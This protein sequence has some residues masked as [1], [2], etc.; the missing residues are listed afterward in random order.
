MKQLFTILMLTIS[1]VTFSQTLRTFNGAFSDSRVPNGTATY[2]FYEDPETREYVKHGSF[3]YSFKGGN[4]P[5]EGLNQTITGGFIKGL[6]NGIWTYTVSLIDYGTNLGT[7]NEY[8]TGTIS[9]VANYNNG[10]ADGNWKSV[11]SYKIRKKVYSYGTLVWD[12]FGPLKTMSINM[13]FKEGKLVGA[14]NINDGFNNFKAN[15]SYDN[16]SLCTGT[17]ILEESNSDQEFIYKDNFLYDYVAREKSGAVRET[18]KF[19]VEYDNLIEAREMNTKEREDSG[20]S[21]DTIECGNFDLVCAPTRYINEYFGKLL[22]RFYFL[23]ESIGGD[24]SFKEGFSGGNHLTVSK[25]NYTALSEIQ[26]FKTAEEKYNK[27]DFV[28]A[29]R[30]YET[31]DL[32]IL[33]PD[34]KLILSDKIAKAEQNVVQLIKLSSGRMDFYQKYFQD[35]FINLENDLNYFSQNIGFDT[36]SD[37]K[38]FRKD[39]GTIDGRYIIQAYINGEMKEVFQFNG[40]DKIEDIGYPW[41]LKNWSIAKLC[42]EK[43]IGVFNSAQIAI[44]EQYFQ[45]YNVLKSEQ[46]K[47]NK[48]CYRF[49]GNV[50]SKFIDVYICSYD[51]NEMINTINAVKKQYELSKTLILLERNIFE[52]NKKINLLNAQNMKKILFTKYQVVYNDFISNDV[53]YVNLQKS[54][55]NYKDF[56]SFSDQVVRLYSQ[57]TKEL[58]KQLKKDAETSAQIKSIILQNK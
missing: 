52:K 44:T 8:L 37:Y 35:Q 41:R 36:R 51:T 57:D 18:K 54:F 29:L 20:I 22:N 4:G 26:Q 14:L 55:D 25:K 21:I 15:G 2:Q 6:K 3:A 17:W 40:L 24:L 30:L 56:N 46:E 16:N 31:I 34:E 7:D 42:F 45:Y 5:L 48:S 32:N 58:E 11:W 1:I 13:N 39:D 12:S 23:Y 33:K 47:A 19:Q 50:N 38:T 9:L 28:S 53:N 43:N 10:Y 27:N 49:A